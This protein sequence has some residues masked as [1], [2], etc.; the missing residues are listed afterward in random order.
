MLRVSW[1]SHTTSACE[2]T[3]SEH[4]L[5]KN[6]TKNSE[7]DPVRLN[8]SYKMDMLCTCNIFMGPLVQL[9]PSHGSDECL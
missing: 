1:V 7:L 6:D 5:N 8:L 9:S 4:R 2:S 3:V